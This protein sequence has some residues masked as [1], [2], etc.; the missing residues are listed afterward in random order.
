MK[1]ELIQELF[2]QF[3]AARCLYNGVECWSARE[4]QGIE[5]DDKRILK[6]TKKKSK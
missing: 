5:G 4:L 3:E 6:E 1:K 2:T